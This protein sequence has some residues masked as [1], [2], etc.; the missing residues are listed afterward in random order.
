[1]AFIGA[2]PSGSVISID[3]AVTTTGPGN[4]FTFQINPG[5]TDFSILLQAVGTVTTLS[6][7]LQ[8]ST[9]GGTTWSNVTNR[10]AILT[11]AAPCVI[12][13]ALVSGCLYRLNYTT[14]SGSINV[15]VASN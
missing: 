14:A 3:T 4:S 1:M 13:G 10:T 15:N 11:S 2:I 7:D 5:A 9:D 12:I 6:A 8:A